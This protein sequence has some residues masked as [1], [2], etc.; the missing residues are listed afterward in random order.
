MAFFTRIDPAK[1]ISRFLAVEGDADPVGR[2]GA[3]ARVGADRV[4]AAL[5]PATASAYPARFAI[6]FLH[7]LK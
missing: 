2:L 5:A 7:E 6:K 1:N 4:C 3:D